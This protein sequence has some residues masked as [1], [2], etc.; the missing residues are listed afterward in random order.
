MSIHYLVAIAILAA[1]LVIAA[2]TLRGLRWLAEV[3][4]AK[5]RRRHAVRRRARC[6]GF[7]HDEQWHP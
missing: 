4:E 6:K 5:H 7:I 2:P 1:L 3:R